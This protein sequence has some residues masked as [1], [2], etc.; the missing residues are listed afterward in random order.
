MGLSIPA[1]TS[2]IN[3]NTDAGIVVQEKGAAASAG[4][5][6]TPS[7]LINGTLIVGAQPYSVFKQALDAALQG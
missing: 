6:S 4:V 2:C 5:I 3:N 7:F 1:F